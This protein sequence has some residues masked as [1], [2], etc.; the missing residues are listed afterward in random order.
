MM[1]LLLFVL[2][3]QGETTLPTWITLQSGNRSSMRGLAVLNERVAWFGGSGGVWGRT[4]DGGKTWQ[5]GRIAS[6]QLDFRDIH[7]I[8]VQT[9]LYMGAGEG[10]KSRIFRTE[11][12]G[13][14]WSPLFTNKWEK[15]F[16]NTLAFWDAENG[17]LLSDPIDD[18]PFILI[19]ANGGKSWR[20][21]PP[22]TFP[23]LRE[24][25]Y[26][27]AA[28]GTCIA[29]AGKNHIWLATGGS[30]ARVFHSADRGKTWKDYDSPLK[31]GNPSSGIFSIAFRDARHGVI[32]GG[33]YREERGTG[34]TVAY[35][36]DGGKTWVLAKN[37]QKVPFRSCVAPVPGKDKWWVA[38]GPSGSSLSKNDG[39]T[40]TS[41][42]GGYHVLAF[43]DKAEAGLAAGRNGALGLLKW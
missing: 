42:P 38:V 33:N 15:G 28:S 10:K 7:I 27:F 1:F 5:S 2:T 36:S 31:S 16:F 39:K 37:H 17:L 32:V 26:G 9:A 23:P 25:E 18:R 6:D 22:D 43:G 29:L 19:T 12:G 4:T 34:N 14:T 41:F 13:K 40:W 24:G 20:R 30:R 35:T 3:T 21:I 8:D 11:D